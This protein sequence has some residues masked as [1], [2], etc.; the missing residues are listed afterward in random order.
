MGDYSYG[1]YIYGFPA[2]QAVA[3]LGWSDTPAGNM[4]LAFPI[5]LSFAVASWYLVEHPALERRNH[6]ADWFAAR[7][8]AI[9]PQMRRASGS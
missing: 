8:S 1:L 3:Q 4:L 7:L 9:R 5:A 6:V 2:Q